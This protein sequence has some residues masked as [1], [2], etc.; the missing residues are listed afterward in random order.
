MFCGRQFSE[1]IERP[2]RLVHPELASR[3]VG[4]PAGGVF[5]FQVQ[6]ATVC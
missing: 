3:A 4:R 1:R 2:Q 5:F 6:N